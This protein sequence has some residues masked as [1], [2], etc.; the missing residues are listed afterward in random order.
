MPPIKTNFNLP[1][2]VKRILVNNAELSA[3]VG[4]RH[5]FLYIRVEF[6]LGNHGGVL[7]LGVGGN[8]PIGYSCELRFR[9]RSKLVI[10]LDSAH[11]FRES[12]DDWLL[13]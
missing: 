2:H 13:R 5:S 3:N 6:L 10:C 12:I 4:Q 7:F 8:P 11:H 1:Q 9:V